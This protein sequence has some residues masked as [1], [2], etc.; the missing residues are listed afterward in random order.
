MEK[1]LNQQN[2]FTLIEIREKYA[3]KAATPPS[4]MRIIVVVNNWKRSD[5]LF[6]PAAIY[7]G[8]RFKSI[9][10]KYPPTLPEEE[11]ASDCSVII[12]DVPRLSIDDNT[13]LIE[14]ASG[15]IATPA[16]GVFQALA[17][18]TRNQ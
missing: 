4:I 16:I 18:N 3:E 14:L 8:N 1:K 6:M 7:N 2:K 9:K 17:N 15:N 13:S 11:T 12:T 10:H 5:Y